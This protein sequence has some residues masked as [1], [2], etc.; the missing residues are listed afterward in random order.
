MNTV[1]CTNDCS[2]KTLSF[3]CMVTYIVFI[4][5]FDRL[6]NLFESL[7]MVKVIPSSSPEGD[8]LDTFYIYPT[9]SSTKVT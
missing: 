5:D 9:T 3:K 7:H 6:Y 8:V 1:A 2:M 4:S